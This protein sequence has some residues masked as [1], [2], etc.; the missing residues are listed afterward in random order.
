MVKSYLEIR[1]IVNDAEYRLSSQYRDEIDQLAKLLVERLANTSEVKGATWPFTVAEW[2]LENTNPFKVFLYEDGT[3]RAGGDEW[4]TS[5]VTY[6]LEVH[7]KTY[8][9]LKTHLLN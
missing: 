4:S 9:A 1:G 7:V 3:I 2:P 6:N 8:N 5:L